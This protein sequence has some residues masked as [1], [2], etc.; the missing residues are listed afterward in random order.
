MTKTVA[1]LTGADR[2]IKT[3]QTRL[4]FGQAMAA[5]RTRIAAGKQVFLVGVHVE[6][7]DAALRQGQRGFK[8]LGQ[9]LFA[10]GLDTQAVNHDIDIVLFVFVELGHAVEVDHFSVDAHAHK[11]LCLQTR[12]LI[13]KTAF[14]CACD[15]SQDRQPAL[16]RPVQYAIDHLT[17]VLRGER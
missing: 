11:P 8:T 12:A 6:R 9:P 5:N 13:F 10:L 17:D 3:K 2:V 4:Q 14:A 7:H 16:G 1:A 15:W